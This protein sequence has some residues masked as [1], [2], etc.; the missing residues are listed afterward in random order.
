M[1]VKEYYK[2][3]GS[4]VMREMKSRY[5]EEKGKRV[6]YAT[7]KK[8]GFEPGN[9]GHKSDRQMRTMHK[10]MDGLKSAGPKK[11]EKD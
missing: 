7:A 9:P 10:A 8:R 1:P 6:F 2:G 3:R 11:K 4:K 5:G